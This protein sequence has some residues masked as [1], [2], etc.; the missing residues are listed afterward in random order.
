MWR[1]RRLGEEKGGRERGRGRGRGRGRRKERKG[2]GVI[3]LH[4]L[5]RKVQFKYSVRFIFYSVR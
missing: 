4:I 3:L 1:L 5:G 2:S